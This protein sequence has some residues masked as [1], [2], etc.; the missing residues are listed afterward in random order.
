MG[1]GH[2]PNGRSAELAAV[3]GGCQNEG[4]AFADTVQVAWRSGGRANM[5]MTGSA[6]AIIA[7]A[8][9]TV[10][11][12]VSG[13]TETVCTDPV[14][15]DHTYTVDGDH[16]T[17]TWSDH[18]IRRSWRLKCGRQRDGSTTCH[19]WEHYGENGGG[20]MIYRMLPDGTLIE[21]GSWFL[22]D[23]SIVNVTAGFVCTTRGE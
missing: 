17:Y 14:E 5:G 6:T 11:C 23:V 9:M 3:R 2:G 16:G 8:L 12:A 19:R 7:A 1:A 10:P 13:A 21:A 4:H 18:G 20:V 22:I 15:P